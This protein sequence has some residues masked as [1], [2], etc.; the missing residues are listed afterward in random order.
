GRRVTV[1]RGDL[2]LAFNRL[3]QR[4]RRNRVW[5]ELRRTARHEKKGY[6]RRRLE[7]ERWRKQF[8]HEV[9]KKVKLVDTIRRR[10]A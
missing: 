6:K 10:G 5:Y 7:S 9:R 1:P 8:A 3:N 4:L 2:G